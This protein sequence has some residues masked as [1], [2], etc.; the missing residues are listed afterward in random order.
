MAGGTRPELEGR[1]RLV[2]SKA[3]G[4]GPRGIAHQPRSGGLDEQPGAAPQRPAE[5]RSPAGARRGLP[6]RAAPVATLLERDAEFCCFVRERLPEG[7]MPERVARWLGR[8]EERGLGRLSAETIYA[9]VHRPGQKGGELRTLLPRGRAGRSRRRTRQPC[10]AI[11][12]RRSIHDRPEAVQERKYAGHRKGDLPICRRIRPVLVLKERE[13]R[14]VLAARLA[15]KSAA[16]TVAVGWRCSAGSTC[17]CGPRPPSMT[18]LPSPAT[19]C[20]RAPA[21]WP[22]RSLAQRS[23][24]RAGVRHL[25]RRTRCQMSH[26]FASP[27]GVTLSVSSRSSRSAA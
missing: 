10:S 25:R 18:T 22:T 19:A 16:E 14:F 1:E 24:G 15:G 8:G 3:E 17:V 5:G 12:G 9:F 2:T 27:R 4:L 23:W 20:W 11:A 26:R 6:P 21:L 13:I 7:W